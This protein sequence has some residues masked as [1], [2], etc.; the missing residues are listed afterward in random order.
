[1]PLK[2][3]PTNPEKSPNVTNS[4]SLMIAREKFRIYLAFP[5]VGSNR[6]PSSVSPMARLQIKTG[7]TGPVD[8]RRDKAPE[9]YRA[10]VSCVDKR[11]ARAEP[12][13]GKRRRR[14]AT[15]RKPVTATLRSSPAGGHQRAV[16]TARKISA[17]RAPLDFATGSRVPF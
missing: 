11:V 10:G 16:R 9:D 12:T 4:A 13:I 1:M 3:T 8:P 5:Y 6:K 7:E 14:G 17:S 15:E 2:I